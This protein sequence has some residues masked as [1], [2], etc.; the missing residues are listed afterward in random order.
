MDP[1]EFLKLARNL[2]ASPSE[3][4][5]RTAVS[6]AYYGVYLS[7]QELLAVEGLPFQNDASDHRRVPEYLTHAHDA[8]ISG[9]GNASRDLHHERVLADYRMKLAKFNQKGAAL[10]VAKAAASLRTLDALDR[11]AR[12]AAVA[13]IRAALHLP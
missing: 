6:R 7:A 13:Q 4:A 10:I 2:N 11:A 9:I 12:R 1:R 3:A 5:Q 8:T